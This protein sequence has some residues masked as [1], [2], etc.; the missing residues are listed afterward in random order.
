MPIFLP[1]HK[2]DNMENKDNSLKQL[3]EKLISSD[4]SGLLIEIRKL[5]DRVARP[6]IIAIL[7][8]LYEQ[9]NS[10]EVRNVIEQFINDLKEQK[11]TDELIIAIESSSSD[12]TKQ[13]LISSCWQS[14]LDYSSYIHKFI[15]YSIEYSYLSTLECYSVIEEWSGA[16]SQEE[17]SAWI[18]MIEAS[19]PDQSDEKKD[20][21]KAIISI[22]Q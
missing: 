13:K 21:L 16:S 3:K 17:R 20:L 14:G 15:G 6:G 7:G 10:E 22:L 9:R 2:T 19:L 8:D 11:L 12:L 4:D 1:L 5:R 18:K